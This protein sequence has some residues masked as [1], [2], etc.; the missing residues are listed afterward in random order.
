[1]TI[2]ISDADA[3]RAGLVKGTTRKSAK[4]A[5]PGL[6]RAAAG[7]GDRLEQLRRIAAYGYMPR[8]D[9][10]AGFCFWNVQTGARTTAHATYAAACI[11]AEKE[12]RV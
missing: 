11:A 4:D 9:A 12:V 1:M 8:W 6:P 7:E 2:Y 3:Q 5:R 10:G